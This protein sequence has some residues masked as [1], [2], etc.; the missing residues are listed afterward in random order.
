MTFQNISL[1]FKL[2]GFFVG[3]LC[4]K[5]ETVLQFYILHMYAQISN[6]AEIS[7]F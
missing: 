3:M 7:F 4:V 6:C 2:L 1:L 5:L